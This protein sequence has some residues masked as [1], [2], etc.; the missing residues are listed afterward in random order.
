[1]TVSTIFFNG[2]LISVPGSYTEVDASGLESVGLGA[3][4]FVALLGTSKGGKPYSAVDPS[5]VPGTLQIATRAQ[6]GFD[7]FREG[8]L[9]EAAALTFGPSADPDVPG[10]AQR[11]YFCKVNPAAQSAAAFDNVDGEAMALTSKDYGFHTTQINV[12]IG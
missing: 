5:N 9:R 4:G 6:Q 8:D 10:G 11:I 3:S 1:M 2:R 7:W 12:E